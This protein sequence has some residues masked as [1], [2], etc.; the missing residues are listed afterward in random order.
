MAVVK[1]D[2]PHQGCL[3]YIEANGET[4]KW[5]YRVRI[6]PNVETIENY[7]I[8]SRVRILLINILK[9]QLQVI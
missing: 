3:Y 6:I 1:I 4:Y 2:E 8:A 7:Y 5:Q 9:Y